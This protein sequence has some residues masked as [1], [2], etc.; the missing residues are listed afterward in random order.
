VRAE[1]VS[2]GGDAGGVKTGGG[3]LWRERLGMGTR[4]GGGRGGDGGRRMW[5]RL[6]WAEEGKR[7]EEED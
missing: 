6:R 3:A 4:R 2:W 5:W 1:P 7:D